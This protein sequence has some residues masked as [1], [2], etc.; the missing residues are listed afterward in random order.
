MK[1]L[2]NVYKRVNYMYQGIPEPEL[3][4]QDS[5]FMDFEE[6]KKAIDKDLAIL[7][8]AQLDFENDQKEAEQY[9][10]NIGTLA[11]LFQ[12]LQSTTFEEYERISGGNQG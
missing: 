3:L 5:G 12:Q 9:Q 6:I 4:Q 10:Q 11:D 8:E 1:T 7:E 2:G